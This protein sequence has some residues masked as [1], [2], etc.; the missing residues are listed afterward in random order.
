MRL[1]IPN[2]EFNDLSADLEAKLESGSG[3]KRLERRMERKE[4]RET[5]ERF[6]KMMEDLPLPPGPGELIIPLPQSIPQE[7]D[8]PMPLPPVLSELDLGFL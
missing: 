2:H 3:S 8:L 1:N 6:E 5:K 4:K 7:L